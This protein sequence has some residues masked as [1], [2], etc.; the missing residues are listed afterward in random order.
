METLLKEINNLLEEKNAKI[1]LLEW[2]VKTL[3]EENER[4]KHKQ[5]NEV[6]DE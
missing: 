4:L 6:K 5:E 1:K 2:Q 3:G